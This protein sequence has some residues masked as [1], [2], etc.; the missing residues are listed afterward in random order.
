MQGSNM[1]ITAETHVIVLTLLEYS[2]T[3]LD[4]TS[5]PTDVDDVPLQWLTMS[6]T[7]PQVEQTLTWSNSYEPNMQ[8][9]TG[10]R[11]SLTVDVTIDSD[12]SMAFAV[13][14]EQEF[15]AAGFETR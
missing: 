12:G 11:M 6:T 3:D 15:S 13:V 8:T 7:S 10:F 5:M 14:N 1:Y 9:T 2:F 4:V